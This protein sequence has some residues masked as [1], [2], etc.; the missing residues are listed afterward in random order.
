M[1]AVSILAQ[2]KQSFTLLGTVVTASPPSGMAIGWVGKDL[3]NDSADSKIS[4]LGIWWK[5]KY[6]AL[7]VRGKQ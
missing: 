5:S 4:F 6:S 1:V 2:R 3:S 7:L